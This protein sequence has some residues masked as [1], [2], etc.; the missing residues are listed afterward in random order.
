MRSQGKNTPKSGPRTS[1]G[2][3]FIGA[4]S[5]TSSGTPSDHGSGPGPGA[6]KTA[7]TRYKRNLDR[8]KWT[9]EEKKII[10]FCFH[11]SR[12][13]EW[14]RNKKEVF[15][16]RLERSVLPKEKLNETTIEKLNS[17]VS[18]MKKYIPPEEINNIK[19]E[20]LMEAKEEYEGLS[21]REKGKI[22]TNNW[23]EKEKW[24][25]IWAMHYAQTKYKKLKDSS[26]EWKRIFFHHCPSKKE[27]NNKKLTLQRSNFLRTEVFTP[28]QIQHMEECVEGM[29]G[30]NNCPIQN[31]VPLIYQAAAPP[32]FPPSSP[33]SS[34][35]SA[36]SPHSRRSI[37][38][39][40]PNPGGREGSDSR[41]S[42]RS[43]PPPS[44]RGV[45]DTDPMQQE[46]EEEL[47]NKI[48]EIK[49]MNIQD[50]PKLIRL[51]RNRVF[52]ALLK[53][54]NT[55]IVKLMLPEPD[56]TEL[57]AINFA[58]A[59]MIQERMVG[60]R[61]NAGNNKQKKQP[62]V[63][64]WKAELQRKIN[65]MRVEISQMA[66]FQH[67]A[68]PSR[69]LRKSIEKIKRKYKIQET[70]LEQK[71][72]HL[73]AETKSAAQ[74]VKNK[75]MW[76]QA[77]VQNKMFEQNAREFYRTMEGNTIVVKEPPREEELENYWR[78]MFEEERQHQEEIE[79][80]SAIE[81]ENQGKV[82]MCPIIHT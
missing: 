54:I 77:K 71:I 31:P 46:I 3:E 15:K 68:N 82:Q 52:K 4:S 32:N 36:D 19:R 17:I 80:T 47:A 81:R 35:S 72:V 76:H 49:H 37:T 75:D 1:T 13:E 29:I 9:V 70:Q 10:L 26:A 78:P 51:E 38:I 43:S 79:I 48:E 27:Y 45:E 18:Q 6:R 5:S 62:P 2:E 40:S 14:G 16:M 63:P 69:K 65:Q 55:A 74:R 50:R 11:Y 23:M 33:S 42:D 60:I 56:I 22:N 30:E 24:V 73:R 67:Q 57:N 41:G 25:L 53:R 58:A 28:E 66:E 64:K 12:L 7:P 20:A 44:P 61:K 39:P 34:D 59:L 21:E 8:M